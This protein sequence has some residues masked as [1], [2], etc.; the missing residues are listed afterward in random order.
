MRTLQPEL[1]TM[2]RPDKRVATARDGH[3]CPGLE[4]GKDVRLAEVLLTEPWI[5]RALEAV[6]VS[7][8][9]DAWIGAGV[10]R[11]LVWGRYHGRFDPT[12]VKDI[13]VAYFDPDDLTMERDLAAQQVLGRL[14]ELPWEAT[15][16]AAVHT[17]FHR[18]FG[19]P[20]VESFGSVH[21]A[22]AT[23]PETATCV[24]VRQTPDG[25][26]VCA[27]HGLSDL[28]D[29]VWRVNPIRVTPAISQ[30]RLARQRV[31]ARWPRVRVESAK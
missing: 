16:Q 29:G 18:Y 1:A 12:D 24:A 26:D 4:P 25:I 28:L 2:T 20:P 31:R 27:P 9:P 6:A 30:E 15:N 17:W 11:D 5:G 22:V 10:I 3:G 21:D 8:L 7:G 23:W 13:D 19:G 14:A